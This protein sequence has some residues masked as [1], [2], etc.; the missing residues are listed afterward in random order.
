MAHYIY[1]PLYR[2]RYGASRTRGNIGMAH[3]IYPPLYRCKYG[4]SRTRGNIGM[5]HSPWIGVIHQSFAV[6]IGSREV[7]HSPRFLFQTHTIQL[8]PLA[9]KFLIICLLIFCFQ[10]LKSIIKHLILP[11]NSRQKVQ[12]HRLPYLF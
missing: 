7:I 9:P 8:Q 2:R 6:L 12:W 5:V 1:P 10:I 11:A 4:A 3:Y